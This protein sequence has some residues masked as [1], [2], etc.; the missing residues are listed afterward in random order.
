MF[1]Q[2][3][4]Y[5]CIRMCPFV[6]S[7]PVYVITFSQFLSAL[8]QLFNNEPHK[9][10]LLQIVYLYSHHELFSCVL[11]NKPGMFCKKCVLGIL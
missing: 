11:N 5:Q 8:I 3:A 2:P 1:V 6:F 4:T 10:A 7:L 9:P